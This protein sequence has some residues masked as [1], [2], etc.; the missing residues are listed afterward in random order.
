VKFYWSLIF[1]F[2]MLSLGGQE[3]VHPDFGFHR[4]QLEEGLEGF[5][6]EIKDRILNN[7]QEFMEDF[8]T[9][10]DVPVEYLWLVDKQ[11][12]LS[13]NYVPDDLVELKQYPLDLR[14]D[15]KLRAV[16]MDDLVQMVSDAREEG[17]TLLISSAYRSYQVQETLFNLYVSRDGLEEAERYSARP[18]QSQHQLGTTVDFG[19]VTEEFAYTPEGIWLMDNA[20]LY[21]FS[22]SYPRGLEDITGYMWEPWHW[23][24]IGFKAAQFQRQWFEDIQQYMLVFMDRKLEDIRQVYYPKDLLT[25]P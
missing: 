2:V 23:R 7:A 13:R 11:N 25:A 3:F 14:R 6:Q 8:I 18:G 22:L 17:L 24:Y 12:S 4:S 5:P 10:L 21:G 9:I 16:I 1:L 15:N 20:Y 19:S